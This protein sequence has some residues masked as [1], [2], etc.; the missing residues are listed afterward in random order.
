MA[1]GSRGL[2]SAQVERALQASLGAHHGQERKGER[3]PYVAHPFHV[4]LILASAGGDEVML[5]AALLHDVV[6]DCEGWT[7]ARVE[8]E[9][10]IDVA[11][12]VGDLTE[13]EGG[14]WEVR[15]EAALAQVAHM[16]ADALAVKAAD[17]LHNMRSLLARLEA[18]A[19]AESVW[20]VFSRGPG[21]TIDYARRL[22]GA[23]AARFEEVGQ[24]EAL[25][26]E[27]QEVVGRLERYL[28]A[29]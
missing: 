6:E 25:G 29:S 13:V 14:T 24:Y 20:K 3:T 15:K 27:L 10:G 23:L 19:D 18:E 8:A 4:A 1:E 2:F 26:V 17:K 16:Q 5:Q 12:I 11:R 22:S 9:F 7:L 28:P 21:P